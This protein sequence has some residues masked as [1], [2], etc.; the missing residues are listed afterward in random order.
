VLLVPI[1]RIVTH[2]GWKAA[3][4]LHSAYFHQC[5]HLTIQTKCQYRLADSSSE[6][7]TLNYIL[8]DLRTWLNL[9][10]PVIEDGNH[11]GADVQDNL[12]K[13]LNHGL[14]HCR[15]IKASS[16]SH[17]TDRIKYGKEWCM[18]PNLQ[19]S[20][21]FMSFWSCVFGSVCPCACV[22]VLGKSLGSSPAEQADD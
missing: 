17:F 21:A 19:V 5:A 11:F 2:R 18:F 3:R 15:A 20:V 7:D 12:I 8:H 4:D 16:Q 9:E 10:V 1:G 6:S 13:E 14:S 22:S